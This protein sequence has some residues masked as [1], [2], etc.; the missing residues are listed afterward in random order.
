MSLPS[1]SMGAAMFATAALMAVSSSCRLLATTGNTLDNAA[2]AAGASRNSTSAS[3]STTAAAVNNYLVS[4]LTTAG[5]PE[6]TLA[7]VRAPNFRYQRLRKDS[8]STRMATASALPSSS[9]SSAVAAA[10]T[11]NEEGSL[12]HQKIRKNYNNVYERI[13]RQR[14]QL[15]D[16]YVWLYRDSEGQTTSW[17]KYTVTGVVGGGN[18]SSNGTGDTDNR[19]DHEEQE[20]SSEL[21]PLIVT[22]EMSTKFSEEESYATHHRIQANLTDRML[23]F[24]NN[25]NHNNSKKKRKNPTAETENAANDTSNSNNKEK[26]SVVTNLLL[27]FQ[28]RRTCEENTDVSLLSSN[29]SNETGGE[30]NEEESTTTTSDTWKI[31]FEYYNPNVNANN[32]SA[33]N[34]DNSR[35]WVPFG[36][37]ENTQ[38]FEEKFDILTMLSSA[39][40][41]KVRKQRRHF[42]RE[43]SLLERQQPRYIIPLLSSSTA[44]EGSTKDNDNDGNSID[45]DDDDSDDENHESSP[46]DSIF[47]RTRSQ[48]WMIPDSSVFDVTIQGYDN[49]YHDADEEEFFTNNQKNKTSQRRRPKVTKRNEYGYTGAWYGSSGCSNNSDSNDPVAVPSSTSSSSSLSLPLLS[50]VALYKEFPNSNHTFTLIEMTRKGSIDNQPAFKEL[51]R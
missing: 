32:D 19:G 1:S 28:G 30:K 14:F 15:G 34:D 47:S 3:S 12:L 24:K 48:D 35:C 29:P 38:A 41:P 20:E 2:A 51:D 23:I 26:T 49:Y 43:S 50:G 37:G 13:L 33:N 7:T 9:S 18:G 42:P 17:E 44:C 5:P 36:T 27:M 40:V 25:N 22:L 8:S 10:K 11:D 16:E 39:V 4:A 45:D 21:A 46:T 6:P 31:G